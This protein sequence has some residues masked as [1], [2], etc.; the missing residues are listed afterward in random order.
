[1][2][3]CVGSALHVLSRKAER[4]HGDWSNALFICLAQTMVSGGKTEGVVEKMYPAERGETYS[5]GPLRCHWQCDAQNDHRYSGLRRHFR[6]RQ[7]W[8]C[9]GSQIMFLSI[10]SQ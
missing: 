9:S 5:V 2:L 1:M 10:S 7:S 3:A 8:D 4:R 6:V